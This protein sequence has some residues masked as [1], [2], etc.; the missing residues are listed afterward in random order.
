MNCSLPGPSVY[1]ILQA[2]ILE[3]VAIP[4]SRR[5]SRPRVQ[6]CISY[7]TCI[8]NR[9]LTTSTTRAGV[10]AGLRGRV[11]LGHTTLGPLWK[12]SWCWGRHRLGKPRCVVL[13]Q[14]REICSWLGSSAWDVRG[15]LGRSARVS[16]HIPPMLSRG[17]RT[18]RVPFHA[19]NP[20]ENSIFPFGR[21]STVS[22]WISFMYSPGD[23][24]NHCFIIVPP[25]DGLICAWAPQ[26]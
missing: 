23:F 20:G 11:V 3:W 18:K 1:R 17:R 26:W 6:T 9:V 4:F 24:L 25:Q 16:G 12:D 7:I 14:L 22:K 2:R 21:C 15:N 8:G 10:S 13:G 5:S 19:S